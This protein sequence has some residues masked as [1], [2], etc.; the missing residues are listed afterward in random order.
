M[1]FGTAVGA[2]MARG[3]NRSTK[4]SEEESTAF[5]KFMLVLTCLYILHTITQ[6]LKQK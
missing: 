6:I 3:F 5:V 4:S 2:T 1:Q